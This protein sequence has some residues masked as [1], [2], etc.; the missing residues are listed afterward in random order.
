VTADEVY[1][2]IQIVCSKNQSGYVTP[3]QFNL[4]I[5]LGG[6]GFLDYLLGQVEQ[7]QPG[8]PQPRVALGMSKTIRLSL[9]AVIDP[10]S[11]IVI[12]GTGL[13]PYPANLQMV[14]AMF[15]TDMKRIRFVQQNKLGSYLN[16]S[17]TPV[18]TNPIFLI[19][20]AGFQ[21][22]PITLGGAKISYVHTPVDII[23]GFSNN[24]NGDPI[25]NPATSV[26]PEWYDADIMQVI[27]RALALIGVNLQAPQVQQYAQ[28]IKMQG[29]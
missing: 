29:Q 4:I 16:S 28:M 2:T 21:F 17:V 19:D 6:L 25:Y 9:A 23:W 22:Y 18:A 11:P 20:S 26:D 15:T 27:V 3:D 14:D 1:R 8:R 10:I 7:Y 5:K 12:D 13:A 24:P